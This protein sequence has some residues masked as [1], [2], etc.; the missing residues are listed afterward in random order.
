MAGRLRVAQASTKSEIQVY[1]CL[2]TRKRSV[3]AV[4]K[5]R[6]CH[7]GSVCTKVLCQNSHFKSSRFFFHRGRGQGRDVVVCGR[8]WCRRSY[9]PSSPRVQAVRP[10]VRSLRQVSCGGRERGIVCVC[11]HQCTFGHAQH[12]QS[13]IC[14]M[15]RV[16]CKM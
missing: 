7:C 4:D 16:T 10:H 14:H 1:L 12:T 6:N 15:S 9:T 13:C 8:E 11:V 5:G 2:S 3:F